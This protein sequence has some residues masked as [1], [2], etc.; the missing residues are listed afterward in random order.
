MIGPAHNAGQLAIA[1]AKD[2]NS[3]PAKW[4]RGKIVLKAVKALLQAELKS[5]PRILFESPALANGTLGTI[6]DLIWPAPAKAP[7]PPAPSAAA[8]ASASSA[9][10]ALASVPKWGSKPECSTNPITLGDS[11]TVRGAGEP[12]AKGS[13]LSGG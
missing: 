12:A 1:A 2:F 5:N 8:S 6:R 11:A 9:S 7:W 4:R 13:E 3:D 10:S